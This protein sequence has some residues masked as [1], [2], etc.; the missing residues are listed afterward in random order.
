MK[1]TLQRFLT[2]LAL[3]WMPLHAEIDTQDFSAEQITPQPQDDEGGP[4]K[5]EAS[6]DYI[7]KTKFQKERI[8]HEHIR[9]GQGQAELSAVF[10]YNRPCKEGALAALSYNWFDLHWEGNPAFHKKQFKTV[11]LSVAG[12]TE[13]WCDWLW[14]AQVGGNI[15]ADHPDFSEYLTWDIVLWGRYAYCEDI[16]I[17]IGFL[18]Q[19][20]MKIDRCYPIFGI[21]WQYW[22]NLKLSAVYPVNISAIYTIDCHWS[23]DLAGRFFDFRDRAGSHA[24][25]RKAVFHYQN[26]GAEFG[27]NYDW[28]PRIDANAHIGYS[29]GGTLKIANQHNHHPHHFKFDSAGYAGAEVDVRF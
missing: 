1:H 4:F 17:N 19:T 25:L 5:F 28:G 8:K 26:S 23:V 13:R 27:V 10:Y 6:Y 20:G 29:F 14:K 9:F 21:D 3:V 7:G 18:A 2:V 11:T 12:F 16:G 22:D 24:H 15:D